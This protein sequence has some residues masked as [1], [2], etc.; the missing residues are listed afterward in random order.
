M[1]QMHHSLI[2]IV[3]VLHKYVST[4]GNNLLDTE[5][6]RRRAQLIF[7]AISFCITA[8]NFSKSTGQIP[9]SHISP[10]IVH[11]FSPPP[12]LLIEYKCK[13]GRFN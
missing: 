12:F 9:Y 3:I 1:L 2:V 13:Y 8:S 5:L 6:N 7:A 4:I 11:F 10:L